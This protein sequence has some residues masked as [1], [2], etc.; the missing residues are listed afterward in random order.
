MGS[1]RLLKLRNYL[2]GAAAAA[3]DSDAF[4]FELMASTSMSVTV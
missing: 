2:D 3:D 4:V 1:P